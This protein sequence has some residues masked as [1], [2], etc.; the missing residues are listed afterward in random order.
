VQPQLMV[1]TAFLSVP[2]RC[3]ALMHLLPPGQL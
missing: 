3:R 1:L 2:S